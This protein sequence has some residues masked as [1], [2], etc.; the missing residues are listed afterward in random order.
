M[1]HQAKHSEVDAYRPFE[2]EPN[3]WGPPEG[4]RNIARDDRWHNPD[5]KEATE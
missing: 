4:G 3:T 2:Y 5:P 1:I